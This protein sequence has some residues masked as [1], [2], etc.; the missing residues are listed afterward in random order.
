MSYILKLCTTY[1]GKALLYHLLQQY[2]GPNYRCREMFEIK[3]RQIR[4]IWQTTL[5]KM[6]KFVLEFVFKPFATK[7]ASCVI[8]TP[9]PSLR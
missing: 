5:R 2:N 8:S 1:L 7:A 9:G 6:T 4:Y 3:L